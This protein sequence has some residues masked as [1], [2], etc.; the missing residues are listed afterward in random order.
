MQILEFYDFEETVYA[1][2]EMI[3]GLFHLITYESLKYNF[4]NS[5]ILKKNNYLYIFRKH[6][7]ICG[8]KKKI[9]II[10]KILFIIFCQC[11]YIL[12]IIRI[13]IYINV[14]FDHFINR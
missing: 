3:I 2:N 6:K 5:R 13:L 11:Y 8:K 7:H 14:G 10:I 9:S 1:H 4:I 12:S